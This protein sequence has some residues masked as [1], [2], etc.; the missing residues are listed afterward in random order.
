MQALPLVVK[1]WVHALSRSKTTEMIRDAF[2]RLVKPSLLASAVLLA[3]CVHDT[4]PR[5]ME[6]A[7][8]RGGGV[9]LRDQLGTSAAPV[10]TLDGGEKVEVIAKRTRWV[11]VRLP[12][13]RMG[14]VHSS[15]L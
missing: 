15:F 2:S 14:W 6:I 8:V 13:G 9:P 4:T 10:A 5:T 1:Y 12:G 3:G 7:Y 11:Q